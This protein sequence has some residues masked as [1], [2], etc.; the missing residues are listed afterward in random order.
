[1]KRMELFYF[2]AENIY[3]RNGELFFKNLK[4]F[5]ENNQQKDIPSTRSFFV[6]LILG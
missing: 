2:H 3:R 5:V 1:M 4:V 6:P